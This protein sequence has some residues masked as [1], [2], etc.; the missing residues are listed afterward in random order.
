MVNLQTTDVDV[1]IGLECHVQINKLNTKLFCGC[2]SDYHDDPPNT[3]TCP[4][5]LGL[6]GALPV[7]NRRAVECGIKVA[8]ALGCKIQEETL[9]Y[10]KN[11]Y[12]PDLPRGFQI[13]QYDFPLATD[14][15]VYLEKDIK[16]G[17]RINRVHMEEDPGRLVHKGAIEEAKYTMVDYNRSG[18]PLLEI[19][20]EP[21][22]RSPREARQF[23]NK[24]RNILEYLDVFD[25]D[26]EGSLRVDA[27]ISINGG[28]RTEVKNISSYKGVEKALLFELNRQKNVLRRGKKVEQETRHF[29][30]TR[31]ITIPLRTK[32][33]EYDYRYFPEPDLVLM[34]LGGWIDE[35]KESLPELPDAKRERFLREYNISEIHATILTSDVHLADFFEAVASRIDPG[36]CTSWIADVLKGELNY[37]GIKVNRIAKEDFIELMQLLVEDKITDHGAIEVIRTLL[38]HGGDVKEIVSEKGLLKA[39]IDETEK[40][41]NEV[42]KEFPA[43]V[44]DYRSGKK[45]ALNYLVGQVMRKTRGRADPEHANR[46]LLER[47]EE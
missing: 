37:R 45:E 15:I 32:E 34:R 8:L 41:V 23:L 47:I 26:L 3:H 7:I 10:R 44:N 19:V 33:A 21:D 13:S 16:R 36:I 43:A 12:Y 29:D 46:L 14:G 30:E 20:T 35:I 17:I 2:S 31:G 9:F 1:M 18:M 5:C 25:G 39:E 22:L 4:V 38:D 6:P 11:Y 27:N 42:I 40:A 28:D 24:I